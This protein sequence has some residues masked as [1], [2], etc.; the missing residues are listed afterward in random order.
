MGFHT[1]ISPTATFVPEAPNKQLPDYS[2][3][4]ALLEMPPMTL[5]QQIEAGRNAP[6]TSQDPAGQQAEQ[7]RRGLAA[8]ATLQQMQAQGLLPATPVQSARMPPLPPQPPPPPPRPTGSTPKQA[9][10]AQGVQTTQGSI[11]A[12]QLV[13]ETEKVDR[14]C[15]EAEQAKSAT[16]MK[17]VAKAPIT[18]DL[19]TAPSPASRGNPSRTAT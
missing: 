6:M 7:L 19:Q 5:R 12:S 13:E 3:L 9:M 2:A 14:A 16:I 1:G 4:K 10:G 11:A 8:Q 15:Y 17:Q 18:S